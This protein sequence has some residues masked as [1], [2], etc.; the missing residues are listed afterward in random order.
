MR[1]AMLGWEFPPFA[2]GGLG[3]HCYELT[4]KLAE[5]GVQIDFYMPR[6]REKPKSLHPNLRIIEVDAYSFNAYT[7]AKETG[8]ARETYGWSL[9]ERV[10][11]YNRLCVECAMREVAGGAHY[12]LIH[13]HDWLTVAA[14][15]ELKMKLGLPIVFTVHSTEY[16]RAPVPWDRMLWAERQ[17]IA[18]ADRVITVSQRMKERMLQMGA[19]EWK[20]RVIYNA[21]DGELF[22]KY[23]AWGKR[24]GRLFCSW[25]EWWSRRGRCSSSMPRRW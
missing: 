1:V 8:G 21:V 16:D 2:S 9:L 3:V 20:V 5:R 4:R 19:P 25:G 11:A 14:A 23:D 13:N 10:A 22:G 12:N 24:R 6:A 17:G 7:G 15:G 18:Q